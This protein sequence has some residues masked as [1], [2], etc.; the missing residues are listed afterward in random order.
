[1][2]VDGSFCP[3]RDLHGWVSL[4]DCP[5]PLHRA[6]GLSD[7]QWDVSSP[8]TSSEE[9]LTSER[10]RK[11][12][13]RNVKVLCCHVLNSASVREWKTL[14]LPSSVREWKTLTLLSSV[15]EWKTLTLP[16]LVREWKTFTLPSSVRELKKNSHYHRQWENGK[17]IKRGSAIKLKSQYFCPFLNFLIAFTGM[18]P[19]APG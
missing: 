6:A 7:W 18:E 9:M 5:P 12:P 17:I 14:T 15:K 19:S 16:S 8:L 3:D 13:W 10:D 4:L 1:M 11:E 2:Q